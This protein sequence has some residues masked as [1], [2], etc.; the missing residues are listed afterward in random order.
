VIADNFK[1][2]IRFGAW[3]LMKLLVIEDNLKIA[4]LLQTSLA[5]DGHVI[6]VCGNGLQGQRL[7]ASGTYDAIVLDVSLPGRDGMRICRELRQQ[8]VTTPMLMLTVHSGVNDKVRGLDS[9]ADDYMTKPF[10][11]DELRARVRALQR[12]RHVGEHSVLR[13]GNLTLNLAE[14]TVCRGSEPIR[15]TKR[16][17]DLL[18]LLMR[19]PAR[20]HSRETIGTGVWDQNFDSESNVI[21]VFIHSLRRKINRKGSP[22]LIQTVPGVGYVLNL[23]QHSS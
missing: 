14:R 22:T 2:T 1:N 13:C 21:D 9:G 4:N 20:V 7:A 23:R 5:E 17:F 19:N 8:G 12:R 11:L 10:D 6:S 18:A 16:E 15:L 3:V